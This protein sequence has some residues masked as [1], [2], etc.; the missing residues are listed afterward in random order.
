[1]KTNLLASAA[2]IAALLTAA[3]HD[4]GSNAGKDVSNPGQSAPVNAVQDVAATGVG[5]VAAPTAATTVGTYVPNAAIA[6]MYEIQAA[7]IAQRR[8]K[9]A[10]VKTLAAMII[11]DHTAMSNQMKQTVKTAAPE[12]TLPTEL[13]Q[14]RKGMIDNLNAA[15]DDSFDAAY[16]HQQ[17]AAHIEALA[18][19]KTFAAATANQPLKT[20]ANA[21]APKIQHHLDEVRKI[22]GEALKDAAPGGDSPSGAPAGK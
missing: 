21:A 18:L 17:L 22:G 14:R 1:M 6:D 16:L 7:E 13:D 19:H 5:M 11:K 20:L 3:C 2:L 4:T 9:R 8:A 12:V 10:E 15:D